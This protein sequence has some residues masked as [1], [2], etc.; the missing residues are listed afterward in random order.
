[1]SF[2]D[3]SVGSSSSRIESIPTRNDPSNRTNLDPRSQF[4]ADDGDTIHNHDG[5]PSSSSGPSSSGQRRLGTASNNRKR[6]F[7]STDTSEEGVRTKDGRSGAKTKDKTAQRAAQACLRCR[8]QK[9]RCLGGNPCE[10]CVKTSN[11]CDFGHTGGT[12]VQDTGNAIST[13]AVTQP[14]A[15][16]E[17]AAA[18]DQGRDERLKLLETSVANLL[19]GLAEEPDISGQG[20]PHL[21]I[22]HE[23]VKHRKEPPRSTPSLQSG[24]STRLPPPTHSRPLDPIRFGTGSINPV[25]SPS[26]SHQGQQHSISP[27]LLFDS[28]PNEP[29]YKAPRS[30]DAMLN[31]S[32]TTRVD[33]ERGLPP[34]ATESLYE[35]PFRSL[36]RPVS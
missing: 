26:S 3:A 24:T 2:R 8:R 32:N 33:N 30:L 13:G 27:A 14:M 19:A 16:E 18:H 22:F 21:E 28:S 1:M 20:Y 25:I 6:A 34:Q 17:P 29:P 15:R 11:V 31:H 9:L 35:A 36:V 7:A 10:R 4:I 23:V 12:A 5:R